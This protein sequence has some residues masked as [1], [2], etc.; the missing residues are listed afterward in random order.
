MTVPLAARL[1]RVAS[2]RLGRSLPDVTDP[3]NAPDVAAAL[4]AI[5]EPPVTDAATLGLLADALGG[6]ALPEPVAMRLAS[7][8]GLPPGSL[9]A[10]TDFS[11]VERDLLREFLDGRGVVD[12]RSCRGGRGRTALLQLLGLVDGAGPA[13]TGVA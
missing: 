7:G 2:V 8:L 6:A 10:G 3:S 13:G 5:A 4:G 9:D 11:A 1:G 12:I